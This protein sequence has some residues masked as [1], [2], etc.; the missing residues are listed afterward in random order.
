MGIVRYA[1]LPVA[2]AIAAPASAQ[3]AGDNAVTAAE[4]AFGT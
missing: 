3:R 4:D 1:L 2:L